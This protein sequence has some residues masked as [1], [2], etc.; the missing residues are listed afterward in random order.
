MAWDT[1]R[2]VTPR[3]PQLVNFAHA[4]LAEI[5]VAHGQRF[6]HQQ[7]L[8]IHVNRHRERQ[9]HSHAAR[10]C[11]YRLIDKIADLREGGDVGVARGRSPSA[12]APE[13]RHSDRHFPGR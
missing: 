8:G 7:N 13:W 11:L 10:V 3:R 4:P 12:K 9:A 1:K 6:V 2:I 5:D